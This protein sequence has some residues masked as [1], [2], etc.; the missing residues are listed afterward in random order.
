MKKKDLNNSKNYSNQLK[1]LLDKIN[2]GELEELGF[3]KDIK[4]GDKIVLIND[5]GHL[6]I[7]KERK[8]LNYGSFYKVTMLLEIEEII[9]GEVL[10]ESLYEKIY[11]FLY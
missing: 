5:N 1:K 6:I 4:K 8:D 2:Y 7:D 3:W 10:N 9:D 11:T